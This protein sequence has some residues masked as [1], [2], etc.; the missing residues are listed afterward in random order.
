MSSVTTAA[1]GE[2][3]SPLTP[4]ALAASSL[5]LAEPRVSGDRA[6]W[7]EG[8]AD[9]GGRN[10]IVSAGRDGVAQDLLI[11]PFNA[12]S[13]VHEYGGG[14]F[15]VHAGQIWFCNDADQRIYRMTEDAAHRGES[16][17]PLTPEGPW[18]YADLVV[19]A[20]RERL[21]CVRED[22]SGDGEPAN[23]LVAVSTRTGEA[24]VLA[25]G[26]DFF[27]S[28]RV[29]RDGLSLAYLTW[30]HP[31]MPWDATTLWLAGLD[32]PGRTVSPRAIA[33][34]DRE[35]VFQPEFAPD[36]SLWFVSDRSD[37]W[38]LYQHAESRT[39][40][41]IEERAEYGMPQWV[42]A[43]ATY[44]FAGTDT[45]VC[46]STRN[47]VWRIDRR[48]IASGASSRWPDEVSSLSALAVNAEQTLAIVGSPDAP[49]AVV[50]WTNGR[51]ETEVLA[52]ATSFELAAESVS[53]A[54][55]VD[56]SSGD[57]ETAHGFFYRPRN[58]AFVA[59]KDSRP[60]LLVIGHGGPTGATSSSFNL[61]VQFWTTR[62]FAVLDVNYRGST[63]YGRAY[64]EALNG[65][66]GVVDVEDCVNG[67][68]HLADAGEVD[69]RRLIIRGGSAGGFTTLAALTFHD[70]FA[71][72]ASYYGIG[73]LEALARDTHKFE[74]RYLDR[75]VGPYP[76]EAALYRERSPINH[77]DRLSCPVIFFQGLEDA[78]VPPNQ[79]EMMREAL[80]AK[81]IPVACL[82]F[83]GEQHGFRKAETIVRALE[84]ELAFYGK[85]LGFTPAGDL[86]PVEIFN[87]ESGGVSRR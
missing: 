83:E 75:L 73:E 68:R 53:R 76:K 66:W 41:V 39:R 47:G 33:G 56:F 31:D 12:R 28:P 2:W 64:R 48:A 42:F 82:M 63:G 54:E 34:G 7:L 9:E 79:A 15:T 38:N 55:A 18:R 23:A 1:H 72:G 58:G 59:A 20:G 74:S 16:P 27:A 4:Q 19:D 30:D 52:R 81:G 61:A 86:P 80:V 36:G 10:V 57:F 85:V 51:A 40:C 32:A 24:H 21:I 37:W 49:S 78:V 65:G 13:R 5:R 11:A 70:T 67:A 17:T 29:S 77:V 84:A 69:P 22:H 43:M 25:S 8:R 26:H 71:A 35:S 60:P 6:Y 46:A 50:R 87:L 45:L 62:G 14:A 3:A 44:G